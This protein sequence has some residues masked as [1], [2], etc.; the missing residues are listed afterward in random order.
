[1][2]ANL[3]ITRS[4]ALF[5]TSMNDNQRVFCVTICWT[6]VASSVVSIS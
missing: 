5:F 4:E 3:V 1:M 6:P 2:L